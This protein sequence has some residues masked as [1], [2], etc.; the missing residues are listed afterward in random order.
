MAVGVR[1]LSRRQGVQGH[2]SWQSLSSTQG[3]DQLK[4]RP[5][6]LGLC[7]LRE[8][9]SCSVRTTEAVD[10]LGDPDAITRKVAHAAE[11]RQIE[12]K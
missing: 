7:K 1:C 11:Q 4:I 8:S 5:G 6:Q 3:N 12:G 10:S 9:S 2:L